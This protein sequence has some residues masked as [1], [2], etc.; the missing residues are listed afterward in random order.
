MSNFEDCGKSEF[1]PGIK[2]AFIVKE[3][4][5]IYKSFISS[6]SEPLATNSIKSGED[7]KEINMIRKYANWIEEALQ[8]KNLKNNA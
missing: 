1:D 6:P 5:E 4:I 7:L 8:V 3:A 2:R